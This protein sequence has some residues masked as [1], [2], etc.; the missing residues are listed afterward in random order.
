MSNIFRKENSLMLASY[1]L[2]KIMKPIRNIKIFQNI[3]LQKTT[4]Q[5]QQMLLYLIYH[6]Q[7]ELT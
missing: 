2:F 6:I 4:T 1:Y 3:S 5:Q 7:N